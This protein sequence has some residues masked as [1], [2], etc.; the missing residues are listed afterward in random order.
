[1][2]TRAE[3]LKSLMYLIGVDWE[4]AEYYT[5]KCTVEKP[6]MFFAAAMACDAIEI[7]LHTTSVTISCIVEG[8]AYTE[9]KVNWFLKDVLFRE[10]DVICNALPATS[11]RTSETFIVLKD[12]KLSEVGDEF[13]AQRASK[14]QRVYNLP[15]WLSIHGYLRSVNSRSLSATSSGVSSGCYHSGRCDI[16]LL[17]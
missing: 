6:D 14:H 16:P 13:I 12:F 7:Q 10:G 15:L 2:H 5:V 11:C 1:V 3:W 17:K 8:I 4:P 9:Y